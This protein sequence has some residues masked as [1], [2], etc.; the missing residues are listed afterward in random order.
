MALEDLTGFAQ[1]CLTT[2]ATANKHQDL[3]R[4][5]SFMW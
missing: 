1:V 3:S 2:L 4:Q 5:V